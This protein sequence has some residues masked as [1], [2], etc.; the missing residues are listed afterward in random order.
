MQRLLTVLYF[1]LNS[2]PRQHQFQFT[3]EIKNHGRQ[4]FSSSGKSFT[5]SFK[6]SQLTTSSSSDFDCLVARIL[7]RMVVWLQR[8]AVLPWTGLHWLLCGRLQGAV[9]TPGNH[10]FKPGDCIALW[11]TKFY[12]DPSLQF[13]PLKTDTKVL[14]QSLSETAPQTVEGF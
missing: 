2:F 14:R 5:T 7:K 11:W 8:V 4:Y 13:L 12:I 9:I 1:H 6:K 10:Y 3:A